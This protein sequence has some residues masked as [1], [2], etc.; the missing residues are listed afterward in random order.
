MIIPA[1]EGGVHYGHF[2]VLSGLI[3]GSPK[4]YIHADLEELSDVIADDCVCQSRKVSD[5]IY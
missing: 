2:V 4:E 1:I 3:R 5:D